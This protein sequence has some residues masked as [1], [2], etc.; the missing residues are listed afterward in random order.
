MSRAPQSWRADVS[1][2]THL[3]N[4]QCLLRLQ[5]GDIILVRTV[6]QARAAFDTGPGA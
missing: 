5:F 3:H 2:R 6:I 1:T 4:I